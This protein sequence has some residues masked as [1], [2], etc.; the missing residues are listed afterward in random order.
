[1][2]DSVELE[3]KILPQ[4]SD[5]SLDLEN[6]NES[7][8]DDNIAFEKD[9]VLAKKIHL[10]NDAIDEMG[11]T[12]HNAKLFLIAGFGYSIDSQMGMVQP[13]VGNW[14]PNLE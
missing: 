11:F 5:T 10:L 2:A 14:V 12:W 3:K 7:F 1:M 4:V 9:S 13:N 8:Q 6:G